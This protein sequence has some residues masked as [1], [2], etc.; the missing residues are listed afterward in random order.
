MS[1][2]SGNR[3]STLD[4]SKLEGL[5]ELGCNDNFLVSLDVSKNTIW[6]SVMLLQSTGLS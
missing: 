2:V 3:I 5:D 6:K 1:S 4:V